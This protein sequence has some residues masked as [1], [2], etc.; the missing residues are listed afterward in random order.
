[1]NKLYV[2][3]GCG[4]SAPKEWINF[5][6]SPTLIIQKTPLI[7]RLLR[8]RLN[9]IFPSNVRYGNIITG[10]PIKDNSCQGVY[11]SHVLEHLSLEDFRTALK[12]TYK[13]L[14]NGGIFRCVVPDLEYPARLYIESLDKGDNLASIKF[15]GVNTLLGVDKRKRFWSSLFGSTHHLWMWDSKSLSNELKNVGFSNIR[16]CKSNDSKNEMFKL[17]EDENRFRN[18]VAIECVK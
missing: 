1:M 13:I 3:Y 11:C 16:D 10:L 15:V 9:I 4:L 14:G 7:G 6:V 8:N 17:V 5:D 2:Q 18:V 12:N